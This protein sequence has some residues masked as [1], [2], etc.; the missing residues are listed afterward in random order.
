AL[1]SDFATAIDGS[2]LTAVSCEMFSSRVCSE[3][4]NVSS[5]GG[6]PAASSGY[7]STDQQLGRRTKGTGQDRGRVAGDPTEGFKGRAQAGGLDR[8]GDSGCQ[9]P[10]G[11]ARHER[12]PKRRRPCRSPY[13]G[14]MS[15]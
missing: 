11:R 13:G 12:R 15:G 5:Y 7:T 9:D 10:R 8:L 4:G 3:C 2:L 1:L 6:L 14:A